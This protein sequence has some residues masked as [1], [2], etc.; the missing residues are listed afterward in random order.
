MVK[1]K[2]SLKFTKNG[3]SNLWGIGRA[4]QKFG[5]CVKNC[6]KELLIKKSSKQKKIVGS[7]K[8]IKKMCLKYKKQFVKKTIK[9]KIC[10]K[11]Q[12]LSNQIW[13]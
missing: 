8:K 6:I 4:K 2:Q 5:F 13:E 11:S 10:L 1:S 3:G 7:V 9:K 12:K